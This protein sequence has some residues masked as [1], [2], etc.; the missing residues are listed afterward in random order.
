MSR[1]GLCDG[2]VDVGWTVSAILAE[3]HSDR[4]LLEWSLSSLSAVVWIVIEILI[5]WFDVDIEMVAD[6][7]A[8]WVWTLRW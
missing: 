7:L 3:S 8:Y 1:V 5:C 6:Q 4:F 2:C